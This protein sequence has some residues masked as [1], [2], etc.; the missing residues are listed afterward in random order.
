MTKTGCVWGVKVSKIKLSEAND[1]T[2]EEI[3]MLFI[4]LVE[5]MISSP[6]FFTYCLSHRNNFKHLPEYLKIG[7]K[8]F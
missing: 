1:L 7:G 8:K 5:E 2:C 6:G 3:D 4:N